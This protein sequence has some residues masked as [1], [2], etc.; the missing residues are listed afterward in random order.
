M[1]P[2][3]GTDLQGWPPPAPPPAPGSALSPPAPA[4]APPAAYWAG[5]SPRPPAGASWEME[6]NGYYLTGEAKLQNP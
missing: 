5:C 2:W 1:G 3:M 4:A 6:S